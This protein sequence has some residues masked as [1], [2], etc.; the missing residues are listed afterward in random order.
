MGTAV[1]KWNY[2]RLSS[3]KHTKCFGYEILVWALNVNLCS[4]LNNVYSFASPFLP[5]M[6]MLEWG[7]L[8]PCR[9]CIGSAALHLTCCPGSGSS[10]KY[11]V[12]HCSGW[13]CMGLKQC[14]P[15][16]SHFWVPRFPACPLACSAH[17]SW[18]VKGLAQWSWP[19]WPRACLFAGLLL[20]GRYVW[21]YGTVRLAAV[22]HL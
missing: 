6:F 5:L 12:P 19:L 22:G 17:Q 16:P 18:V 10:C 2:V 3:L 9:P 4:V 8:E 15:L 11:P 13:L 1:F 14:Q 21:I 20:L 7:L